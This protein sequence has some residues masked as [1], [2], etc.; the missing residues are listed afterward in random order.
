[1]AI[2]SIRKFICI[3]N[4][5]RYFDADYLGKYKDQK[6]YSFFDSEFVGPIWVYELSSRK[7]TTIL[8]CNVRASQSI[9]ESKNLWIATNRAN[10]TGTE[11]LSAWCSCMA[12]AYEACNHIIATLYK[13]EYANNKG[14]C[15]P[16]CTET[17]CQWNQ[18][19][20]KDIEPKRIKNLIVRKKLRTDEDEQETGGN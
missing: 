15:S 11:I 2:N 10:E 14:W 1:M 16:A 6:A 9:H 8:Y 19:T 12:G 13:I 5:K 7:G 20:K 18:S 17:A 3:H 4:E